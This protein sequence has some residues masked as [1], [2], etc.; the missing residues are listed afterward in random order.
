MF[1]K[2]LMVA[3]LEVGCAVLWEMFLLGKVILG[4]GQCLCEL[5]Q[6]EVIMPNDPHESF[7]GI[8][9]GGYSITGTGSR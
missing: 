5:W 6:L 3:F 7:N 8:R 2:L 9:Q 1:C 4:C